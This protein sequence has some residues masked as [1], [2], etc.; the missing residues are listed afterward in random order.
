MAVDDRELG[1]SWTGEP[2]EIQSLVHDGIERP[3]R[4]EDFVRRAPNGRPYI[5]AVDPGTGEVLVKEVTYTRVTKYIDC[6]DEN[7]LLQKWER[8]Q[9]ALGFAAFPEHFAAQVMQWQHSREE[10]DKVCYK[11]KERAG[12]DDSREIGTAVHALTER[13][14]RNLPLGVIPPYYQGDLGAWVDA[15]RYFEMVRIE[16]MMVNDTLQTAGTPDRIVRYLPCAVCGRTLYVLDLKTGR[17]D[18]YTE[19]QQA[20]QLG[21]YANSDFYDLATGVRTK[22]DDICRDKAVVVHLPAGTGR[23]ETQW[24]DIATGWETVRDVVPLVRAAR[25][26]SGLLVRFTPVP[27]LYALIDQADSRDALNR[28]YLE[29]RGI[30]QQEHTDYGMKRAETLR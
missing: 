10:L 15:T 21:L 3:W 8:R 6:I 12:G 25:R 30:W 1:D 23:A 24:V 28:L 7:A 16:E 9:F 29:H 20:M 4:A 2:P 11:A 22:H 26:I 13:H 14:D 27:D 17:V 5:R 19:L 18:H